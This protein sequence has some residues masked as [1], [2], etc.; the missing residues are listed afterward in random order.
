MNASTTAPER[1]TAVTASAVAECPFS[2][3]EEYAA[4]YLQSAEAGREAAYIRVSWFFPLNAFRR[5]VKLSFGRHLDVGEPG[6]SHDEL[7]VHWT[8]GTRLLPDFRG[9]VRFR[10]DGMR[11]RVVIEGSYAVPLGVLGRAFDAVIGK[12]VAL[13]SMQDLADRIA[14]YLAER[15]STW[16]GK[17]AS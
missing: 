2:I 3:A 16:R 6:R 1:R 15:E 14:R 5:R 13:A 9:T 10:I 11:T 12:R 7:R 4:G 8:S 17:Q